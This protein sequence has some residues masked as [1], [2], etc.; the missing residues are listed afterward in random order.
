MFSKISPSHPT[1]MLAVCAVVAAACGANRGGEVG[2]SSVDSPVGTASGA[3]IVTTGATT[4]STPIGLAVDI[5]EGVGQ[6]LKVRAGQTFYIN[7]IDMRVLINASV[8]EGVSGLTRSG[9]FSTLDWSGVGLA[10]Q[11]AEDS[12]NPDGTYTGRGFYRDARW[13][14]ARSTFTFVQVDSHGAPTASGITVD[15]GT[16]D[17]WRSSDAFFVRRLRAIQ[18]TL[19]CVSRTDCTGAQSFQ[20][21]A[22]VEIRD[23]LHPEE[24]FQIRPATTALQV[25]WSQN[26]AKT[27]T[28]PVQQIA[29]PAL[30]YGFGIDVFPVTAPGPDG[31][32]APGS[33]ITIQI[34]LND[35]AGNPLHPPGVLPS[36]NSVLT[37]ADTSGIQYWQGLFQD[38]VTYYRRKHMEHHLM[39]TIMGPA[40]KITPVRSVLN[41]NTEIEEN[42]DVDVANL[43]AD[44]FYAQGYELPT[45]G[46]MFGGLEYPP[47]WDLPVPASFTYHIPADAE[48]GTYLIQQKGRRVYL[49]QDI[50]ASKVIEIQVGSPQHTD[51]HLTVGG[52]DQCHNGDSSLSVVNH[53]NDNLGSC[54]ACHAPLTFELDGPVY[55][56][57]HFLHSRSDR[58]PAPTFVCANCHLDN[59][60]IQRTSKSAC[61]SCHQTYPDWHVQKYGAI[62]NMYVGG[63]ADGFQ[64]CSTTCHTEHPGSGLA[65]GSCGP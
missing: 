24:T 17:A 28:I 1:M 20:E 61:L 7:Q 21:E 49:G 47:L 2:P 63:E 31:T 38:F 4:T 5:E 12:P 43:Q 44:G 16:N 59:A 13:M 27:Y 34:Q 41:L 52:C 30:D 33:D 14:D 56:R 11:S 15:A 54:S 29:S 22:L 25:V 37:G 3:D 50:P 23:S 6:P 45:F 18:W 64:Q 40:Q 58:F 9:D 8:D 26:P 65:G 19:D 51:V 46:V 48:P 39:N 10:E 36:F 57:T 55:V 42:G 60:G 62:D 32:Y 35:G 53:A